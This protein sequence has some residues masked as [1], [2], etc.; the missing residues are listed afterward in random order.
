[1]L[2]IKITEGAAVVQWLDPQ[3]MH[4]GLVPAE[5]LERDGDDMVCPE[6]VLADAE[7][8]GLPYGELPDTLSITDL[9]HR[10]R[11]AGLWTAEDLAR[12]PQRA[13]AICN[14]YA[15]RLLRMVTSLGR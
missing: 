3:G 11:A 13:R 10:L 9:P 14:T 7:P 12:N 8:V 5:M 2:V 15:S 1:M 4:R 6:D